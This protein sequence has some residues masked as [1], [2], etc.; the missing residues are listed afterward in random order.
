MGES[1][2]IQSLP[3]EADESDLTPSDP[4]EYEIAADSDTKEQRI[5]SEDP[6]QKTVLARKRP[7]QEDLRRCVENG[8][9]DGVGSILSVRSKVEPETLILAAETGHEGVMQLMFALG[10]AHPDP[11]PIRELPAGYNTPMLAAIGRG[12]PA[13]VELLVQQT[14]FNPRRTIDGVPYHEIAAQRMGTQWRKEYEI[15]KRAY[16]GALKEED[17]GKRSSSVEEYTDYPSTPKQRRLVTGKELR[18]SR[19]RVDP[20]SDMEQQVTNQ[21]ADVQQSVR[22]R[23]IPKRRR[24]V[25]GKE[26]RASRRIIDDDDDD[27]I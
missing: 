2:D 20:D 21:R 25:T 15:L 5:A 7:T 22:P 26:F 19:R 4:L 27:S 10:Q 14:A 8:D 18:A 9:L 13:I 3:S 16:D 17:S 24:L 23:A 11:A 1:S 12:H 6:K